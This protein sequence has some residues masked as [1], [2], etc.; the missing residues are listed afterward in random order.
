MEGRN[1]V[2]TGPCFH[3]FASPGPPDAPVET[4]QENYLPGGF[5]APVSRPFSEGGIRGRMLWFFP[6]DGLE[7]APEVLGKLPKSRVA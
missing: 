6:R 1:E 2:A 5:L 7:N 4:G 3:T